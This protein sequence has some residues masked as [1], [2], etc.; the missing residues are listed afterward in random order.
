MDHTAQLTDL[1]IVE[2]YKEDKRKGFR[3][4]YRK[5]SERIFAICRRYSSDREGAMDF[6]QEAMIKINDKICSVT[7]KAEGS[8]YGWMYRVTVNLILDKIR[9]EKKAAESRDSGVL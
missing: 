1:E 8:I 6:F 7:I 2:V 3:L 9:R 4:L 5:Y